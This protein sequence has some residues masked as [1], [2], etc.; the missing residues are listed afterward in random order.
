MKH[1]LRDHAIADT[2]FAVLSSLRITDADQSK[3]SPDLKK[4]LAFQFI[5]FVV[6]FRKMVKER[7]TLTTRGDGFKL[8]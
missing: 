1:I 2:P 7:I 5:P 6:F 4:I 3:T 8:V